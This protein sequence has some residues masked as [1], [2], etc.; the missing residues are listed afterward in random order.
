MK[1]NG[2]VSRG[3]LVRSAVAL[4]LSPVLSALAVA[5]EADVALDE[6]VVTAERREQNLQDV[7]ISATVLTGEDM[8]RQGITDLN[9]IQTVAPSIAINVVNRSTFVN[10]RGVG[11]AQSAPT[12]S[13]GVAYYIDGQLIPHEQFIGQSFYDIGSIEVLRGPQ[14][15]LTGQNSTGG[16]IYVR[17]PA[18]QFGSYS[19][20]IEQTVGNY[21]W[22]RTVGAVNLGF[23]D[24]LAVRVAAVHDK[25]DSFTT[26]L[27][28]S[29]SQPGDVAND[30]Q[31]LQLGW[32]A[33]GGRTDLNLFYEHFDWETDNNAVKNR[34]DLV[35]SDPFSI[36]EDARSFMTQQGQRASAELRFGLTDGMDLRFQTSWQD[37]QTEDQTDGDRT[38][39]AKPQPPTANVGRVAYASTRFNTWIYELNLLSRGEGPVQWVLGAFYLDESVPVTLLRDNR[40][41]TDFVASN[42]TIITRADNTSKSVFGQ[43]NAFVTDRVEL[44]GGLRYS[45]DKQYYNRIALPGAP[46]P[47]G[48]DTVGEPAA[49]DEVTGKAGLN[50]HMSDDLLLYG[51]VSKGYKAGGVNLTLNTPDFKPETNLVYEVGWKATMLDNHL[52]VNGDV[53]YSDYK[54][55]QLSSLYNALPLT[56]NAASGEAL[57]AELEMTGRFGRFGVNLGIGWLDAEFAESASIVNTSTNTQQVVPKGAS[58][59]FSPEWTLSAGIDYRIPLGRGTL[60]PRLQWGYIDDQL[61]TPF[62]TT[63]TTVPSRSLVDARLTWES[64]GR[65]AVEAFVTNVSDKTYIASQIQ[66]STSATGG[67]VYGAPQQYGARVKYNFGN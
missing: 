44:I 16:A 10:I 60:T 4:A 55:I 46:P 19:G 11:I 28:P 67:I 57:G 29:G 41:T 26:N 59:V 9:D 1:K 6:V 58:L 40:H 48:T 66:N 49:S 50:F 45:D 36:E 53:F 47:P 62:P 32:R 37:G 63:A 15:T 22:M 7:P 8:T 38:A 34:A 65:W 35:T 54:D 61:A 51:T 18:P 27:G 33:P 14:G 23:S 5:A 42:S 39:T 25:R 12:S 21:D 13:P 30:S 2:T 24:S 17:T 3:F 52:R 43:I 64:D 56:Q 31:R 20:S